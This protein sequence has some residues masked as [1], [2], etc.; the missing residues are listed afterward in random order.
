MWLNVL[1]ISVETLVLLFWVPGPSGRTRGKARTKMVVPCLHSIASAATCV[2]SDVWLYMFHVVACSAC[3]S[4]YKPAT[5]LAYIATSQKNA[6]CH[7]GNQTIFIQWMF[8]AAT[9]IL[10]KNLP[11]TPD[12]ADDLS[13]VHR[14]EYHLH[15]DSSPYC[16]IQLTYGWM[17]R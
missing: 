12:L 3:F 1:K 9:N 17:K 10:G 8:C 5:R 4:R 6:R 16:C 13:S 7:S 11:C 15:A 2:D 14:C